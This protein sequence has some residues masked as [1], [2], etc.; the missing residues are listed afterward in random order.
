M[1]KWTLGIIHMG[2]FVA[3]GCGVT[4]SVQEDEADQALSSDFVDASGAVTVRIKQC[5]PTGVQ[6][7]NTATCSVDSGFVLIGGGAEVLGEGS[8]GAL[9]TASFPDVGLTTWTASSKDQH[10]AFAHQLS[11]YSVGLKLAGVAA[12]TLRSNFMTVVSV[13]STRS[14]RPATSIAVPGGFSLIGGG[15]RASWVT[16]GQ[17]LTRSLPSGS[18]WV[19]ASKDHV[20]AEVGTV[21]A[22]AIGITSGTI[23]GF[24]SIDVAVNQNVTSVPTGYGTANRAVPA[25]WV[26]ASIGGDAQFAG[27]GRMLTDL[28]PSVDAPTASAPGATV[29]S[30]DHEVRDS[31]V[32]TAY[33][34][35]IRKH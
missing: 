20:V 2:I 34:V 25:G 19:A 26:L 5:A 29:R 30:K 21:D 11:A 33:V 9:L 18:Q 23:P 27:S 3:S 15:A 35:A 31:G 12:S 16:E 17:L 6:Q 22:F 1:Y 14:E 13:S 28:I 7:R 8:P 24:G 10:L 32:T 4:P